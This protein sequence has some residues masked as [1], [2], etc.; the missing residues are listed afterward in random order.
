[1]AKRQE[2]KKKADDERTRERKG[3]REV[4]LQGEKTTVRSADPSPELR[5]TER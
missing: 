2:K 5:E 3:E 4:K 1:M